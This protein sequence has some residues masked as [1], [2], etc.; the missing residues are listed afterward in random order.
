MA[1]LARTAARGCDMF[2]LPKDKRNNV[3]AAQYAAKVDLQVCNANTVVLG[4]ISKSLLLS[5]MNRVADVRLRQLGMGASETELEGLEHQASTE[6]DKGILWCSAIGKLSPRDRWIL[7]ETG[8]GI[9]RAKEPWQ[10]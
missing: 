9:V 8:H 7:L 10:H 4:L 6:A 1:I 5:Q 2:F 3:V